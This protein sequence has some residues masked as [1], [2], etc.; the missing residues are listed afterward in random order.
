MPAKPELIALHMLPVLEAAV[1]RCGGVARGV[2]GVGR[3]ARS[4]ASRSGTSD[5]WA[6]V[7]ALGGG[8][9]KVE[10]VPGVSPAALARAI[11]C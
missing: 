7:S 3:C 5:A 6:G 11:C 1:L 10:H 9:L 4:W 2:N 8:E